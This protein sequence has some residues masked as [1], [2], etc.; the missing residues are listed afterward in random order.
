MDSK[1]D[2][3]HPQVLCLALSSISLSFSFN[4]LCLRLDHRTT[5][6]LQGMIHR[7]APFRAEAHVTLI[8]VR[9]L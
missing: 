1:P 9:P 6:T 7:V 5:E 4:I 3:R 2:P 8:S